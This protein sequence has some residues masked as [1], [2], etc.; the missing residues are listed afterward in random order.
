[1]N[2]ENITRSFTIGRAPLI[3]ALCVT[4][5]LV[6]ALGL[7]VGR[8]SS[9]ADLRE[10]IRKNSKPARQ[11][12]AEPVHIA[13]L[14]V[15]DVVAIRTGGG[16]AAI[17]RADGSLWIA[18]FDDDARRIT[19]R[20]VQV[21]SDVALGNTD[22][23]Q[24]AISRKGTV[25]FIEEGPRTLGIVT[26]RGMFH[27]I[28][29]DRHNY[30]SPRFSPDGKNISVDFTDSTG[31]DI[32]IVDIARPRLTRAT[33]ERDAHNAAWMPDGRNITFTTYRLGSLGIYRTRPESRVIDSVITSPSL[34][35][36]GEW[37]HDGSGI[38]TTAVDLSAQSGSDI[39]FVADS[40]RGPIV[41]RIST[42]AR[43]RMPVVSPD[44]KWLAFVSNQSGR[45]QVYISRWDSIDTRGRVSTSGGVE[46][47]WSKDGKTLYYRETSTQYLI[48][49]SFQTKPSLSITAKTPLFPMTDI[50]PGVSHANYDVSPDDSTFVVVRRS[51]SGEV[52]S[53][54]IAGKSSR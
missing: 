44:G 39:A 52:K 25:S 34:L 48:A 12:N 11:N 53:V 13:G 7:G 1:M 26:R 40:G 37:L 15:D 24:F 47:V 35:Y 36:S 54:R 8:G 4:G 27:V 42:R 51:G 2:R 29:N 45:D 38:V 32:W 20:P 28:T 33:F 21:G 5:L 9:E 23:A 30:S 22:E 31:R 41:N 49:L 10:M 18:P 14:N 19:A 50:V 6:A 3:A 17:V 16:R 43:E 46:P